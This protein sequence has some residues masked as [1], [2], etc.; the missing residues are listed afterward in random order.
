MWGGCPQSAEPAFQA[1][2]RSQGLILVSWLSDLCRETVWVVGG[3][4]APSAF[5]SAGSASGWWEPEAAL[6]REA[7][8]TDRVGEAEMDGGIDDQGCVR[9]R[10][11]GW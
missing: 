9:P 1:R 2:E 11:N 4:L 5:G 6:A 7:L 10:I 3:K 8:I